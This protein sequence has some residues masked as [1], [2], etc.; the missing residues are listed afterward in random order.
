MSVTGLR[1]DFGK[2]TAASV[3]KITAA[4][5]LDLA[6]KNNI[7]LSDLMLNSEIYPTD[8]QFRFKPVTCS[9]IRRIIMG[10]PRNKSPG[11]DKISMGVIKDCLPVIL[12]LLT[13]LINSSLMLGKFPDKCKLSEVIP[14]H[15]DGYQEISSNNRPL[16]LLEVLSKVCE[17]VALDQFSSDTTENQRLSPHQ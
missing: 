11:P 8:Q 6:N 17:R 9:V 5:A 1:T 16:S 4:T 10:M 12:G 7:A 3:G 15:K 13:N 2:I 14:L